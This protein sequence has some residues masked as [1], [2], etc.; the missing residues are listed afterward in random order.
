MRN[1]IRRTVIRR[2]DISPFCFTKGPGGADGSDLI[3]VEEGQ[4][5]KQARLQLMLEEEES[6]QQLQERERAIRQLEVGD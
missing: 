4:V 2:I 1:D 5:G 6:L 3:D